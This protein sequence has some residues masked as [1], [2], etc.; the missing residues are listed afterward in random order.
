MKNPI[1]FSKMFRI[2]LLCILGFTA[3]ESWAADIKFFSF[4]PYPTGKS[5][6]KAYG[7]DRVDFLW[8]KKGEKNYLL[9]IREDNA[10]FYIPM[11]TKINLHC[12]N[13]RGHSVN[14]QISVP[15]KYV[16]TIFN[17]TS[18]DEIQYYALNNSLKT[19]YE[20]NAQVNEYEICTCDENQQALL[21]AQSNHGRDKRMRSNAN[22]YNV[23]NPK[24]NASQGNTPN[25]ESTPASGNTPQP[26]TG[27]GYIPPSSDNM[28]IFS[29]RDA[30]R[31]GRNR[32]RRMGQKR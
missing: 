24:N 28:S 3:F 26:E 9:M 11:E 25:T 32:T 12:V 18:I 7:N 8:I 1:G 30:G 29:T 31:T 10:R 14:Q 2:S 13:P 19:G 27:G 21:Q 17:L 5:K 15:D 6:F 20:Y 16:H 4:D 22:F 23:N